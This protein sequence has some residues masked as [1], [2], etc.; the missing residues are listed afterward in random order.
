MRESRFEL[1]VG[2]SV[3]LDDQILTVID[4]SGEEITFRVDFADELESGNVLC[5]EEHSKP[6]PPR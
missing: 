1:S 3:R 6:L 2:D 4:I 5:S